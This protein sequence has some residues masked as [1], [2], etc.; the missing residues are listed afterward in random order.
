MQGVLSSLKTSNRSWLV[1][2]AS[3]SVCLGVWHWAETI[4]VP[5]NTAKVLATHRPIGNNSDLYARW[6]GARELLLHGRDPYSPQVT[7]DIQTGFYGRPL[8]PLS[9]SDPREQESFVYPL[10]VVFLLAPTVPLPFPV[11]AEAFRWILLMSIALSVPLWMYVVGFRVHWPVV[12]SAM[13][14]AAGSNPAIAEYSQQNL[15]ALV[16]LFLAA[17]AAGVVNHKLMLGGFML[18]LSTVKPDI[19]LPVVLWLLAWAAWRRERR[20]LIWAFAAGMA[21][22]WAG[23]QAVSPGWMWRFLAAVR[24]YPSY[25]TDPSILQVLFPPL[26]AKLA[27]VALVVFVCAVCWRGREAAAASDDFLW[28]LAVVTAVT[29]VVIP[30]L[31]A[32][33]QLLLLPALLLLLRQQRQTS[34]LFARAFTKGAFT[35]QIW[36]WSAALGLSILSLLLTPQRLF[37]LAQLPLYTSLA[38]SPLTLLAV[39]FATVSRPQS[40]VSLAG[41]LPRVPGGQHE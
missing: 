9:P 21:I 24:E 30:K 41:P 23:A 15:T 3:A 17:A 14:L 36:Q 31:A 35:C 16:L 11:V 8:D 4:L 40:I 10:Y 25:G 19:T 29:L 13:L 5:S 27:L 7:R 22:L 38:L 34:G 32:Y 6:L 39:I 37:G 20:R 33:N 12:V 1:L 2:A 26:L 28:T 18:A